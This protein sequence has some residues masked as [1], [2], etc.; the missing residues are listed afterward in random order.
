MRSQHSSNIA[1]QQPV[2]LTSTMGKTSLQTS[3]FLLFMIWHCSYSLSFSS[4]QGNRCDKKT[5]INAKTVCQSCTISKQVDCLAGYLKKTQGIGNR[6]CRYILTMQ[7]FSLSLPGCSHVCA[8]EFLDPH[9]CPGYW[10]SDCMECPGGAATPCSNRGNCSEGVAG[11]GTCSC[12]AGFGGTACERCAEENVYG[13]NCNSVCECLHGL[14][15]S[16]IT[17]DGKCTCFS[18][19]R[20]PK[21][22][23]PIPECAA[24]EC[25]DKA[26]CIEDAVSGKLE[27]KCLPDH[28]GDGKNCKPINP[29]LKQ[30][31][32]QNANCAHLGPNQHQCTCHEG[33][34]GDGQVCMPVDPCQINFGNCPPDSS[35]CIYD[36][37][38]KSHCQCKEG[39]ENL[40]PGIGCSLTDICKT[41]NPC[42]KH[43]NCSTIEPGTTE[44]TCNK[45]YVGNGKT[46]Y[47][48]IIERLR[49]LNTEPGGKWTGQLSSAI[50]LFDSS[51]SWPL[52]SL[53]PFTIFVPINKGFKGTSMKSLMDNQLNARYLSKLHVIAGELNI[54]TLKKSDI[55]YTLTGKSGETV[56]SI[57]DQ[58]VKIRIHGSKKKGNILQGDIVASNGLIHIVSKLMDNVEPTVESEK[59]E[60]LMTILGDNGKFSRFRSL[61]QKFN[62]ALLLEQPGPYTI[63]APTNGALESMEEGTLEYLLSSEGS[64]KLL[65]LLRNHIV[66]SV[67]LEVVSIVSSPRLTTMANQVLTFNITNNGQILVN[68]EVV[69]EADIQARN[70]RLYSLDGV[71]IPPSIVPVL[72]HRCDVTESQVKMGTCVSCSRVTRTPCTS[73]VSTNTFK[74]GCVFTSNVIGLHIPTLGCAQYCNETTTVPLCCKGFYGP[75]CSPCPGG[76]TNPCSGHGQCMDGISGNG[77]CICE[78][79]FRG[80]RCQLCSSH[81]KYGPNCDK[82]CPCIH[83]ECDNRPESSG[84]CK[85]GTCQ[86]EY[87]GKFCE[88]H[89]SPCGPRVQFC[90]A[91]ATCDYS[92]GTVSCVCKQGYQGDGTTCEEIDPCSNPERGGCS[93]NAKCIKTGPGTHICQCLVGWR[94]DGDECQEIN[95]CMEP[96]RGGCHENANCIYIG[97]GQSD[98][99]CKTGYRGN[100]IECEPVNPCVEENGGC[101]YMATCKYLSPGTW[102]CVCQ[103]GFV[104]DGKICYGNVATELS[105]IPDAVEFNKWV[106]AA[107]IYEILSEDTNRTVFVPSEGAIEKMN[108]EDKDFWTSN[109]NLPSLIKYH[110]VLGIYKLGDLQNLSSSSVLL[111]SL[112]RNSLHVSKRNESTVI[113]DAAIIASNIAATNGVIH[114]ID[115]VL[116]PD[117]GQ[118]EALPDLLTQLDK[119]PECSIFRGYITQYSLA[120]EIE[121]SSAY[122]VFVPSNNVIESFLK[123]NGST[124]LDENHIRY[125]I[126]LSEKLKKQDLQNGIHKETMLGFSYQLGFFLRENQLFVND[127]QVNY[128]DVET[129]RGVI[130]GLGKVLQVQRNRC[131]QKSSTNTQGKCAACHLKADC[132]LGTE[133]VAGKST[134]CIN[135]RYILG[136]RFMYFGCRPLCVNT[137]IKKD[138]CT[139]FFGAQCESCPRVAG[140]PCFGNGVCQDGVNGTGVCNCKQGFTGTACENCETGKYGPTCDQECACVH[141][142]CSE[143]PS[144][145][146]TCEC[147]VGWRGVTCDSKITQDM[148]NNTCHT[149]ANCLINNAGTSYCKCV[150]GFKGNGISCVA[151][152][153]CESSN[154]GCS[155]KALCKRT[156]PGKR[157]CVCNAGYTGDGVVCVEINP[158][159][160]NNGGCHLNAECTHTGPNQSACN[161]INGYSGN[162]K[163]C[164]SINPCFKKNGGCSEFAICNHTGPAE[165]N[166]TCKSEYIGDGF[167]CKGTVYKELSLNPTTSHYFY[168]LQANVVRDLAGQGPFTVF[169]PS[170]DA[171]KN[172]ANI[173]QWGTR[174]LLP[175]ILRYHVVACSQLQPSELNKTKNATTLQG[176]L[177]TISYSQDSIFLNNKA[178]ILSSDILSSNGIIHIIDKVLVPENLQVIPTGIFGSKLENLTTVAERQGYST[179]S[180]LLQDTNMLGLINNPIHQPVTLFWPTNRAMAAL[181][182]D[183]K[184]FLYNKENLN[185]LIE[186]LKYHI[187]RDG[188]ILAADLPNSVAL[189]T[190]QGSDLRVNC[191]DEDN[192]GALFLNNRKCRIVQRQLE[193]SGGIAHGIDC[194]LSPPSVGGRC[195]T[196][197]AVDL[198]GDCGP[199]YK[200]P[201]CPAGSKPQKTTKNCVYSPLFKRSFDG[202][203]QMCSVVIW[204]SKCCPG[205]F[206]VDCQACPGG[207]ES[208][209][210]SHGRCDEGKEGRGECTCNTGFHGVACELCDPGRYGQ[211]CQV[212]NCTEHGT[213]DE[214]YKGTGVCFCEKGW[215]GPLCET[216]LAVTPV[217]SPSCSTSAVCKENNT[218]ECKPFYE[219]DGRTCTV[220]NLC[221]QQ[222]GGCAKEARCTQKGVT[223]TCS[224]PKGYSGDGYTC[225]AID[226]CVTDNGECH[227][228]ATCTMTG[229]NKRMCECKSGYIGDGEECAVKELPINRC[230]QN[231][232]QCHTDAICTDLHFEDSTVGVFLLRSPQGQYKLVY[233]AAQEG[234]RQE[235]ATIATYNQLSY[236]Q[237]AGFHM[238][239]A[240]WLAAKRVAYPTAYSNPKCGFG[241]VGIVD[242]KV[243]SNLSET[244]DAY[245]YRMKNVQCACKPGYI[246]DGYSCSGNLLQVLTANPIFSNFLSQILTYSNNSRHGEEFL[247]RLSNLT[248]QATLFVPDNSALNENETLSER[249]IEYHLSDGNAIYFG[250]LTNGSMI[251]TRLG[252]S[253]LISDLQNPSIN[254]TTRYV[255]DRYITDWNI[256][257]SNG[258]IHV[259]QEPLRAPPSKPALPASHKAAIGVG[260][261]LTVILIGLVGFAAY[262]NYSHRSRPFQFHYFK[263]DEGEDVAP[264]DVNPS[265]CN[266][267]YEA[268]SSPHSRDFDAVTDKHQVANSGPYD[269]LQDI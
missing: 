12:S 13:S 46:C 247:N 249:D 41:N 62:V 36:G 216:Q 230:A 25:A 34:Q 15:N 98:C 246:G 154:G 32:H 113:E 64:N 18:G 195:D 192:I 16:G 100:G 37:P 3:F 56:F 2:E 231:N 215:T 61:L 51:L 144:G 75:V 131:D 142:I 259:I 82:K 219:G 8:K 238:C 206:G 80:S 81:E 14:C 190:L 151:L 225:V 136:K 73:G 174:G 269:L 116:T 135:S 267:M 129:S 193:F 109:E 241:Q 121:G 43:A 24:L 53:G 168:Q 211:N 264:I 245:C 254:N 260:L 89:T 52:K 205:Y 4:R 26:R 133:A 57:E 79:N 198:M 76:F 90:H 29:C 244:W 221:Q 153:A 262:H 164:K 54:E 169:V 19:Y 187:I 67:E 126:V 97:P 84:A 122:T 237:Q 233:E 184:D 49:E 17:G 188:N 27:C 68:G 250:D 130:H 197:D 170:S 203:R 146:G 39:F 72:P 141:G 50:T 33:Y 181:P 257:A 201:P 207:P 138:C 265:I 232:G 31:C 152:D 23:Q 65:E 38:G 234:C 112:H 202:C 248:I 224:C 256:L 104:G 101:H 105:A 119:M 118:S 222:N 217:C 182:K 59:E 196:L 94:A 227:E 92:S 88:R 158:C 212:C 178:K 189:K 157:V 127:A 171:F 209:C 55:Y 255:N 210:N 7:N 252:H 21:C 160:V 229:P 213:C 96:D 125:H 107:K 173:K 91:H 156:T 44:C 22:D 226:P 199:C 5:L 93:V 120:K 165:R 177:I 99:E 186:Y 114:I 139:G 236:A 261:F 148:C 106:N 180:K 69:L 155:P 110:M 176:E 95:N 115:K 74:R 191:G 87:T 175:Q 167:K 42:S 163:M 143:G 6:D 103:E 132:P 85:E 251:P 108:K 258:I 145:D 124:T 179:F 137:I 117:R 111:T 263:S 66:P 223:V 166:C 214:G 48:S 35:V 10:G 218:C 200:V 70:G 242:Y 266:P 268:A 30:V 149:S 147:E 253:L 11:N 194:M 9:C 240:G 162:G 123:E 47:G 140:R 102:N 20:G 63:F 235:G 150:A 134:N 78:E 161:C 239:A 1:S 86:S 243:R 185:K 228:H 172:E 183:Q 77:T 28:E 40:V 204:K 159:L 71:L 58:Q 60:N 208:P 220:V 128:T 83:G 45:G